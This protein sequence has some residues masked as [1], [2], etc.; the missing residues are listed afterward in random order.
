MT[1]RD[2]VQTCVELAHQICAPPGIQLQEREIPRGSTRWVPCFNTHTLTHT[3]SHT[4]THS[5][6]WKEHKTRFA[7]SDERVSGGGGG[8]GVE[9]TRACWIRPRGLTAGDWGG[10]LD[11]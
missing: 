7:D 2:C 6:Y 8:V 10:W 3:H 9:A 4:H 5:T 11:D 1:S